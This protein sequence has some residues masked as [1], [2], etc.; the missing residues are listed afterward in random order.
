MANTALP[1]FH[2]Y[3][4]LGGGTIGYTRRRVL[5]NN[6]TAIFLNDAVIANATG[7]F[8]VQAT[9]TTFTSN[10]ARGAVYTDATG[11]R[12]ER[13]FLPAATLYTSSG[14]APDNASYIYIVDDPL[15]VQ[16]LASIDAAVAITDLNLNFAVT[17]GAGSTVTGMSGHKLTATGK[18]V[19]ATIPWRFMEFVLGDP[20]S[21]PDAADAAVIVQIN[22]DATT[23][24]L[25]ASLGL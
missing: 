4:V 19:T 25:S 17:L 16:F 9:G 22:A 5:T 1:G 10:V 14:V 12:V 15:R 13:K 8:V 3:R 7:D 11:V 23:P 24:A 2:P 6:T 21:D 18:N 20:K